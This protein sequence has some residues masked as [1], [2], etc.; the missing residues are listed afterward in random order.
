[1]WPPKNYIRLVVLKRHGKLTCCSSLQQLT[2]LNQGASLGKF[3]ENNLAKVSLLKL[4]TKKT[5]LVCFH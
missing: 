1:M 4:L 2:R 5:F 3:K